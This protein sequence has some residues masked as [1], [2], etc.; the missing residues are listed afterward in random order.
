V[1][2]FFDALRKIERKGC[3]FFGRRLKGRVRERER[4]REGIEF[5]SPLPFF[6]NL[7]LFFVQFLPLFFNLMKA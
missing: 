2:L 1:I 5:T 3:V 6:Y 7:L 4:Y